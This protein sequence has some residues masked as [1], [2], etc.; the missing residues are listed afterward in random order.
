MTQLT[1]LTLDQAVPISGISKAALMRAARSGKLS[2]TLTMMDHPKGGRQKTYQVDPAELQ[3]FMAT[4]VCLVCGNPLTC[5]YERN[6]H[7]ECRVSRVKNQLEAKLSDPV[8]HATY[9][10]K[11]RVLKAKP[12]YK[13]KARVAERKRRSDPNIREARNAPR[14]KH[15]V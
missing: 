7:P 12:S 3:R 4:R 14:R 5:A 10:A 11:R 6:L 13:S 1:M 2:A 15:P 8:A 9:Y